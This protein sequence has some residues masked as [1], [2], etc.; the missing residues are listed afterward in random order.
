MRRRACGQ[1]M[2]YSYENNTL[3]KI[4][5]E[6]WIKSLAEAL[7][8]ITRAQRQVRSGWCLPG[9]WPGAPW[10]G[11]GDRQG[12]ELN[13]GPSGH[14]PAR[15]AASRG[16]SIKGNRSGSTYISVFIYHGGSLCSHAGRQNR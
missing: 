7:D 2:F 14:V 16:F 6:G 11:R 8:K 10:W 12:A 15:R 9:D 3:D 5:D 1:K 13:P 4:I